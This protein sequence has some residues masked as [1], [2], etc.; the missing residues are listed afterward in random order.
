MIYKH[1]YK[2]INTQ[3]YICETH[4]KYDDEEETW[5]FFI[6]R[7]KI[8][9]FAIFLLIII[10]IIFERAFDVEIKIIPHA[11]LK[12][13]FIVGFF[14]TDLCYETEKEKKNREKPEGSNTKIIQEKSVSNNRILNDVQT[15]FFFWNVCKS[16]FYTLY[17]LI[18]RRLENN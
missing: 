1:V 4:L 10:F 9:L 14:F 5:V 18:A 8:L 7:K 3:K 13:I 2:Y 12:L 11:T 16:S 17:F 15:V 6:F